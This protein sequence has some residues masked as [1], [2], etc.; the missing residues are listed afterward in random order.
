[1]ADLTNPGL[2][3]FSGMY[4]AAYLMGPDT[5][6]QLL[7]EVVEVSGAIEINRV[8]MPLVG[9]TSSGYK[10]GRETREGTIRLQKIDT[11]WEKRVYDYLSQGLDQRRANRDAGKPN[12]RPFT[13]QFEYDDPDALGIE[14][15]QLNGCMIWRLPLG[16]AITDDVVEREYPLTWES[17]KPVYAFEAKT[18]T[19]PNGTTIAPSW[20]TGYGPPPVESTTT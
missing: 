11:K 7:S 14:K 16:F 15:W 3:R 6:P 9:R 12:L 2:F 1:M 4:G 19:G 5:S 17:E 20:Y 8:D 18:T 10:P 13:I